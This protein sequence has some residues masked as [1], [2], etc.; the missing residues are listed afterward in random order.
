MSDPS[1]I[2]RARQAARRGPL[3][4]VLNAASGSNDA[5]QTREVIAAELLAAGRQHGFIVV[6]DP[7]RL[8]DLAREA[9]RLAAQRDGVV[10][11][12]GGDGT[13][14][15]V[16]QVVLGSGR[17]FGVLPQGTFNYFGR[18]NGIPQDTKAAVRAL[19]GADVQ[20]VQVGQVNGRPFLVNGSLGLYP[21]LLEDREAYK[22][23]FGRSRIVALYSGIVTLLK[24]WRQLDLEVEMDGRKTLLRTPT[25]F[26]GNNRLQLERVGLEDAE[27]NAVEQGR[28]TAIAIKPIGTLAMFGLLVRGLLGQLGEADNITTFAFRKLTVRLRS[29]RRVKVATDGEITWMA[30]PLTFEV[31]PHSLLLMVPSAADRVEVE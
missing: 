4:I 9:L 27:V 7:A 13:L 30:P 18:T 24:S 29:S 3:F 6:D 26:V 17:P 28:L 21:Q 15:A 5:A 10:V 19:L 12:A 25:L 31:S 23:E 8:G 22:Q 2:A 1:V 11:A 14:N 20:A 16:A